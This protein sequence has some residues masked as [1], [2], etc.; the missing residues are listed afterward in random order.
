MGECPPQ[1]LEGRRDPFQEPQLHERGR[2]GDSRWSTLGGR[3]GQDPLRC[4][5]I[6]SRPLHLRTVRGGLRDSSSQRSGEAL[7][8]FPPEGRFHLGSPRHRRRTQSRR[9]TAPN[10]REIANDRSRGGERGTRSDPRHSTRGNCGENEGVEGEKSQVSSH[11]RQTVQID[12]GLVHQ[13]H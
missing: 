12:L 2:G 3:L 1:E 10:H 11:P 9:Q 4:D 7:H 5:P 8:V 13:R 6:R